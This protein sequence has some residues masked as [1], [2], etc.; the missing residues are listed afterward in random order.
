ME[1]SL[2]ICRNICSWIVGKKVPSDYAVPEGK[3]RNK[4]T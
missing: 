3:E 1:V 4:Y 2:D